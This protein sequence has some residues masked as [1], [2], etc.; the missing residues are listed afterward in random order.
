MPSS[1]LCTFSSSVLHFSGWTCHQACKAQKGSQNM[2][3]ATDRANVIQPFG[4]TRIALY[5]SSMLAW[6]TGNTSP[7]LMPRKNL[8]RY[9]NVTTLQGNMAT[10]HSPSPVEWFTSISWARGGYTFFAHK[11]CNS[12]PSKP[13]VFWL[14]NLCIFFYSG[15]LEGTN[16]YPSHTQ[17]SGNESLPGLPH[18]R[19][20][21]LYWLVS[22]CLPTAK[23]VKLAKH[24]ADPAG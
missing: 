24:G 3:Q 15:G 20:P 13:P 1:K 16:Q 5:R 6:K 4:L 9:L 10:L 12:T 7:W 17:T 11:V 23:P 2:A 21:G 19:C 18:W 22:L 14:M 8:C